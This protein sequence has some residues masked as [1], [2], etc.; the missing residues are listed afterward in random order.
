MKRRATRERG[1]KRRVIHLVGKILSKKRPQ[2][3]LTFI[4]AGPLIVERE[5]LKQG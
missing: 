4:K 5:G 1:L 2:K 3:R